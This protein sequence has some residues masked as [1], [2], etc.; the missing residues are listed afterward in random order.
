MKVMTMRN[1]TTVTTDPIYGMIVDGAIAFH[2]ERAGK[3]VLLCNDP[4]RTKFLSA[5]AEATAR[6][7]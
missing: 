2:A 1:T 4:C 5:L 6:D 7:K 3:T